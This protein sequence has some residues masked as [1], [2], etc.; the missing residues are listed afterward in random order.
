MTQS[1]NRSPVGSNDSIFLE[2]EW[3]HL[4]ADEGPIAADFAGVLRG[5]RMWRL[6]HPRARR[7]PREAVAIVA[8]TA[9]FPRVM[10]AES[11]AQAATH[12]TPQDQVTVTVVDAQTNRPIA[13]AQLLVPGSGERKG[14]TDSLGRTTVPVAAL[15]GP[16]I[17]VEKE[18]YRSF[19]LMTHQLRPGRTVYVGLAKAPG[20][21][22]GG[23]TAH[24]PE[25]HHAAV[26]VGTSPPAPQTGQGRRGPKPEVWPVNSSPMPTPQVAEEAEEEETPEPEETVAPTPKPK[27]KATPKVAAAKMPAK[28]R[29]RT[30]KAHHRTAPD[31]MAHHGGRYRVFP[32]DTLWQI[33]RK[34][35]GDPYQWSAIYRANRHKIASPGLIYPGQLLNIPSER[36]ASAA[37]HRRGSARVVVG[38]GD[39]LWDIAAERLGN[40]YRWQSIYRLNRQAIHDPGRI[41][42]GM[43][44]RLPTV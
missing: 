39:T 32:G 26:P 13:G 41:Y 19:P 3:L 18:G 35:Y 38:H 23:Q 5:S 25:E 40:P 15:R 12:A 20:A 10:L 34:E 21:A 37:K 28:K 42:P 2:L 29:M 4:L 24:K 1:L 9:L 16:E 6:V 36:V 43:V 22:T 44:L 31:S 30:M 14:L 27:P 11:P 33:A 7:F 17:V 8:T